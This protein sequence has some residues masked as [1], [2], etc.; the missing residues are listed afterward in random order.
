[1]S[2]S[3]TLRRQIEATLTNRIPSAL[4]PVPRTIRP[5]ATSGIQTVD[6]LLD[7]GLPLG[8]ITE[9]VGPECSGRTSFA[10]SFLARMTQAEKVCAWID[11]SD[12]LDPESAATA[13]IDMS[14]LLWVRCGVSAAPV[15][16]PLAQQTFSIPE[17]YLIPP[18]FKKGLHG[19]G[20]G[21]HPRNEVR[22]LSEAVS[23]LLRPEAFAPR[24]AESQQN[25]RPKKETFTPNF[26][27]FAVK[28]G[29]KS[30]HA[31]NPWTRIEQ[32][33]RVTD[34]VLQGG[35][36]SAIVLDMGSIAPE[37]ASR[38]ELGTWFRYRASAEQTQASIFLLTQHPCA[39]SSAELL[40]RLQ[41]RNARRDEATVF[42]G[43]E[44][45][46]EVVRRHFTQTPMNVIPLRK[47]SRRATTATWHGRTTWAGPR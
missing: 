26:Q 9:I 15:R 29:S 6:E 36:F 37:H 39:K 46:I 10:L 43:V 30:V 25:E 20:F 16:R 42:T 33:L 31:G 24:C 2:S 45:E 32:S 12:S 18:P 5:V 3:A 8:A 7:G 23:G 47:P 13:G 35:G 14:R 1:M 40:L 11:V 4:T 28:H 41:P 27:Q 22:G 44:Y 34:L 21:A 38:V 19:G 17:K